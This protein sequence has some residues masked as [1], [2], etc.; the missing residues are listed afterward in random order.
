MAKSS[1]LEL[2]LRVVCRDCQRERWAWRRCACRLT[3]CPSLSRTWWGHQ[4][5]LARGHG[6]KHICEVV[7]WSNGERG[8]VSWEQRA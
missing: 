2:L 1:L 7:V 5:Q 3:Q 6:G 8:T 4:C